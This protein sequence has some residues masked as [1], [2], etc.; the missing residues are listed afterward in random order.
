METSIAVEHHGHTYKGYIAHIDATSLGWEDHGILTA[1]LH[2][3]WKGSG[4]GTGGYCLDTTDN[5]KRKGTAYGLDHIMQIM[6]TVGVSRWEDLKGKNVI[7]LFDVPM[8]RSTVGQ[9]SVGIA[10]LLNEKVLIYKEHV[11]E[12]K[13]LEATSA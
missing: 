4:I 12:W 10:G 7:V 8:D 1:T 13:D 11:A 5:G 3:S 9:S 6:A 2:L